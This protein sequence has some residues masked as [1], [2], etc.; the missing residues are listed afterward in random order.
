MLFFKSRNAARAF[1]RRIG[2]SVTDR[3]AEH[4]A[5]RWA[6]QII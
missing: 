4:G 3:G 1:A 5:R 2:L 6:V